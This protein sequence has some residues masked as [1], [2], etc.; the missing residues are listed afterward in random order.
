MMPEKI[1]VGKIV[2]TH[3]VRGEVKVLAWTKFPQRFRPGTGLLIQQ[4]EN[5]S[6]TT[7]C[8]VRPMG[9]HLI[10]KLSGVDDVN[11]AAALRGAVLKVEPWAVE[12][13]PEGHY[14]HFQLVGSRVFTVAGEY[15][16]RLTDIL[17]TGANDVYVVQDGKNKEILIPALKT[18]VREIDLVREEIRVE[19][20]PGLRD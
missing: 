2:A 15:L 19:L 4:G 6:E 8:R 13:L 9:R 17:T 18:V 12:P 10:L 16:G 3:G 1:G 11:H 5:I 7:I 14:Y 20:P